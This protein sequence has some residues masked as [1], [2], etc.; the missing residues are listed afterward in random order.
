M[1]NIKEKA[2]SKTIKTVLFASLITVMISGS[3]NLP[4]ADAQTAC[5]DTGVD[6]SARCYALVTYSPHAPNIYFDGL[7]AFVTFSDDSIPDGF[8]QDSVWMRFVDGGVLE[9]GMFDGDSGSPKFVNAI[10]GVVN[11]TSAHSPS[12]GNTYD[13]GVYDSNQD[14]TWTMKADSQTNTYF[15][16][17]NAWQG[18]V[19]TEAQ[20]TNAPNNTTDFDFIY[21]HHLGSWI[22]MDSSTAF[23]QGFPTPTSGWDTDTC[24]ASADEQERHVNTGKGTQSC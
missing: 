19:G 12:D 20:F 5:T 2:T 3:S 21:V 10:D 8:L 15:T 17:E 18:I 6:G 9:A 11:G 7:Y 24:G 14:N 1:T 22:L 23:F 13:I 16:T 4:T